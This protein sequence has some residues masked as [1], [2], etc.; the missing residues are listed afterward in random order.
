MPRD[1]AMAAL[2]HLQ[3]GGWVMLP[4][5]AVSLWMWYLILRKA[6]EFHSLRRVERAA[7]EDGGTIH[8]PAWQRAVVEGFAADR[9]GNDALDRKLIQTLANKELARSERGIETILLLAG[10]APLL[11]LLGTV[12]GMISTFD[13]ILEFG[14]GN[15]RAMSAGISAALITTQSGLV[16]AVP[17]LLAGT[18]L[19]R[20]AH[21]LRSRA[22]CFCITAQDAPPAQE[23]QA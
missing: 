21:K 20:R 17:G 12:G 1:L 23:A 5:A 8:M 10:I 7:S 16:V 18:I 13:S 22:E 15:A 19:M 9:T 3:G 4:L 14:T 6:W 11:G 2:Y